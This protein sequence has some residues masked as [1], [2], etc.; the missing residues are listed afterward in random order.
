VQLYRD[1]Q[2]GG[3]SLEQADAWLTSSKPS[4]NAVRPGAAQAL[5]DPVVVGVLSQ[6]KC[7]AKYA[8]L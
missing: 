1:S 5:K 7:P 3:G 8:Q 6:E 4:Q 2:I